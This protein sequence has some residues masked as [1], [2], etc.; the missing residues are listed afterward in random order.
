MGLALEEMIAARYGRRGLCVFGQ[1][2][3][4]ITLRAPDRIAEG[5]YDYKLGQWRACNVHIDGRGDV[6]MVNLTR[7]PRD[8]W[9]EVLSD[10]VRTEEYDTPRF[11]IADDIV[12]HK[13]THD[14]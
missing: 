10:T 6:Y 4:V 12:I 2:E 5:E 1:P 7:R 3:G 8:Q 11:A 14:G 9:I 13:F